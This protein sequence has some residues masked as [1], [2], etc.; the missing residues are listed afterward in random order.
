MKLEVGQAAAAVLVSLL[1]P[2]CERIEVAGSIRRRKSEVKDIELMT[3]A[4]TVEAPMAGQLSM[5]GG[6]P[7]RTNLL[8]TEIAQWLEQ[9]RAK[10]RLDKNGRAAMGPAYK[11]LLVDTEDAGWQALDLFTVNP[12]AQFGL[13]LLIRTG[14]GVG[15]SGSPADGFGPAMLRRWK[16]VTGGGY[17]EAGALRLP[18][19]EIISTP[20]EADVFLVCR[21]VWVPPEER[22][23]AA[24]VVAA[25]S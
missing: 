13:I 5:F 14:S 9:G 11:R 24:A 10:L 15:P 19:G 25:E 7:G 2:C 20:E 12:P 22:V 3:V 4:K 16:Q 6:E 8:D 1:G 17:S 23:S 21:A 18:S